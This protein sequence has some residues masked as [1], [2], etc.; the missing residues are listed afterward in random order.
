MKRLHHLTQKTQSITNGNYFEPI[1]PNQYM[2]T[3]MP[4]AAA[5]KGLQKELLSQIFEMQVVASQIDAST[6]EIKD[7]LSNQKTL[8]TKIFD[9]SENLDKAN[10]ISQQKVD[11]AVNLSEEML[12]NNRDLQKSASKLIASSAT[13]KKIIATQIETIS[14]IMAIIDMIADTSVE[15][16]A[17][18]NKLF[19]STTKIAEIL[20]TVQTFY[21][22]TKLLALNASIESARAGEAGL[23]FAVVA[24]EITSLAENSSHSV[25]EISEIISEID[26]DI[27]NVID[28]SK[29]TQENVE[30]AVQ[31]SK[32]IKTGLQTI[33]DSYLD[34][35][36]AIHKMNNKI[37]ANRA[38]YEV[39][40]PTIR[41]TSDASAI[42]ADEI[43]HIHQHIETLY[44][45]TDE[46]SKL[47]INLKDTSKSLHALTDKMNV[48]M[49]SQAK[50]KINIQAD[51][52]IEHLSVII[53]KN[54]RLQFTDTA[55][56]KQ[57][58][59]MVLDGSKS[60]EAIWTNDTKGSFIYSNPP[61][62]I[63]NASIRNWF[64]ES[65]DGNNFISSVYISAISKNPCVT[66]SLP[67]TD[68]YGTICGVIGADIGIN[69]NM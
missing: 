6:S 26:I 18:I 51:D 43:N 40:K 53:K 11:D 60:I 59:D 48:D 32:A 30:M 19:S 28:Q 13:S 52:L 16:T 65:M 23:G 63:S 44:E 2:R 68:D 64:N 34:V 21:N 22:Q 14:A 46:I 12:E 62:G 27:H 8:S 69:F 38:L 3:S 42:V 33:D 66:I 50:D 39:F 29:K 45:K 15:S 5:I 41:E 10:K 25:S 47:E 37:E 67:I 4:L 31:S 57:I 24:K 55:S 56:H 54:H 20:K 49:L 61:A 7:V 36:E 1:D 17:S 58:L 9:S 35:T